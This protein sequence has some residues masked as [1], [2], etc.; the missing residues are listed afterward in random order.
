MLQPTGSQRV[1]HDLVTEQQQIRKKTLQIQVKHLNMGMLSWVI[2]MGLKCHHK[3]PYHR[4][5]GERD[6]ETGEE[7][8]E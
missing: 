8:A 7:K 3:Y 2:K 5:S 4:E 1:G 6:T